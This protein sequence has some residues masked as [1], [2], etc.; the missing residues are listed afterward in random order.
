[1]SYSVALLSTRSSG[2]LDFALG[3]LRSGLLLSLGRNILPFFGPPLEPFNGQLLRSTHRVRSSN[4]FL[5]MPY[6][7]RIPSSET[8]IPSLRARPFLDWPPT[9][10]PPT[11]GRWIA[12]V[13]SQRIGVLVNQLLYFW[14]NTGSGRGI[15]YIFTSII[16]L[17][18]S[19]S[20]CSPPVD[21]FTSRLSNCALR[22]LASPSPLVT[23]FRQECVTILRPLQ[24]RSDLPLM[25]GWAQTRFHTWHCPSLIVDDIY[26][27][28][29]HTV[30]LLVLETIFTSPQWSRS[31]LI[32]LESCWWRHLFWGRL[33][34]YL[35]FRLL[36]PLL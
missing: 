34:N 32:N 35:M 19:K 20:I 2:K 4:I 7:I 36:A 12:G 14:L 24:G 10:A 17:R 1:M 9:W 31:L 29:E 11:A 16:F 26:G 15:Q 21:V 33:S 28:G 5:S 27:P 22:L 8:L 23:S 18:L 25:M 13:T 3:L 30:L 6:T